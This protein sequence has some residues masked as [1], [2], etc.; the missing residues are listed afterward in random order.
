MNC[1][2]EI[3]ASAFLSIRMVRGVSFSA[4]L[5]TLQT[6]RSPFAACEASISDFCFDEEA[7]H[8]NPI[9]GDGP[10]DML[11]ACKMLNVG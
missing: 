9:I 4:G 6:L 7:C 3:V 11:N 2:P 1:G 8:A 10:R 5:E